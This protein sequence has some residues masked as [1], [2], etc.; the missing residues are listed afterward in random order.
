MTFTDEDRQDTEEVLKESIPQFMTLDEVAK[1]LNVSRRT[2]N[3]FAIRDENPLPVI[4]LSDAIPRVPWDQFNIW[5][6]SMIEKE[7]NK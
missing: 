1:R 4:Y 6:D 7:A 5:I 3:R 2:V